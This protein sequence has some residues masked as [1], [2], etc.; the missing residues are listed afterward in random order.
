MT[1][2]NLERILSKSWRHLAY[3]VYMC[4]RWWHPIEKHYAHLES[5][6]EHGKII[7]WIKLKDK[8]T[9]YPNLPLTNYDLNILTMI[10]KD[11][12]AWEDHQKVEVCL[13]LLRSKTIK[14]Y[15]TSKHYNVLILS[16][17]NIHL[18]L[19]WKSKMKWNATL[20]ISKLHSNKHM[21]VTLVTIS[22]VSSLSV[23]LIFIWIVS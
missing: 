23:P 19:H 6:W 11:R 7:V 18:R 22:S 16:K 15:K 13:F 10:L 8:R 1:W 9:H 12:S 17:V 20:L 4:W 5:S 2:L 14:S 21:I 3:L